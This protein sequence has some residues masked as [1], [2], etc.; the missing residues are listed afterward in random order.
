MP[1]T[2]CEKIQSL[3]DGVWPKEFQDPEWYYKS[4][5]IADWDRHPEFVRGDFMTLKVRVVSEVS[6][7]LLIRNCG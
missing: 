6:R 5:T 3:D 4:G 2:A 1:H 7:C